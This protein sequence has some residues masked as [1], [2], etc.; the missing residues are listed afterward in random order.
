MSEIN[1]LIKM[2]DESL[3]K[4]KKLEHEV[5]SLKVHLKDAKWDLDR[6][7][8]SLKTSREQIEELKLQ[9][10]SKEMAEWNS[11]CESAYKGESSD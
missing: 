3:E 4:N 9:E 2:L 10:I 1:R 11:A 8:Q 7:C 6:T 5:A